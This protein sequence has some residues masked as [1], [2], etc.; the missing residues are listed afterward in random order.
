ML[1]VIST[2]HSFARSIMRGAMQF[3]R[4]EAQDNWLLSQHNASQCDFSP[5]AFDGILTA[6]H[7]R[8]AT[9]VLDQT[10]IPI[11]KVVQPCATRLENV[12][13]AWWR[14]EVQETGS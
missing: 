1:L 4:T 9:R 6:G 3:A 8:A 2:Q 11:V 13:L 5:S 7:T 10:D 14:G 12:P